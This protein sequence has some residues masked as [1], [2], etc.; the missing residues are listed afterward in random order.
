MR[1]VTLTLHPAVDRILEIDRLLPGGLGDAR[2]KLTVPAGK[3][4]NTARTLSRL[5]KPASEIVAVLW[6]GRDRADWFGEWLTENNGINTACIIR[7]TYT[8]YSS[9]FLEESGRET[10]IKE[11]MEAPDRAEEKQLLKYWSETLLPGDV[12]AVCGSAPPGTTDKTAAQVFRIAKKK[13]AH[14]IIADPNGLMMKAACM[15][16]LDGVKGNAS[17]IGAVLGLKGPLNIRRKEHR[18]ALRF[19]TEK[20][21]GP[22]AILVTLG[23]AGAVFSD[24]SAIYFAA[25]PADAGKLAKKLK[26]KQEL[27]SRASHSATGC[28]DAATAGWMWSI[29]AGFSSEDTVRAAVAFGTA[30][31]YSVDPGFVDPELLLALGEEIEIKILP[32]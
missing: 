2:I 19:A 8:R 29:R 26:V 30:K 14:A 3:G 5:W 1:A 13:K 25:P 31:Y 17:E 10:H 16:G 21:N 7:E 22:R 23:A 11:S 32:S 20:R 18:R 9:T 15:A 6:V 24:G 12:V 27:F 4:V 28:G